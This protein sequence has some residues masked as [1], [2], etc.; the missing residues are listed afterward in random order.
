MLQQISMNKQINLDKAGKIDHNIRN[1][2][3]V[4]KK[5]QKH[6]S[7]I[8]V[9]GRDVLDDNWLSAH[10]IISI[11][12]KNTSSAS[13]LLRKRYGIGVVEWRLMGGLAREPDIA[14]NQ[15]S[16]YTLTDKGQV[17][18]AIQSLEK[19][20]LI[21]RVPS[22]TKT[23]RKRV[24]LTEKGYEI[25]DAHLPCV[26][27]REVVALEGMDEEE[28]AQFFATLKLISKNLDRY[29]DKISE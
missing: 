27:E 6:R 19:K 14:A 3:D 11:A 13:R 4:K 10:H 18:R 16:K 1:I 23:N 25:F 7:L 29:I 5:P 21:E 28:I 15:L 9:N 20:G 2:P 26:V 8:T 22:R 17:S 12:G 24:R